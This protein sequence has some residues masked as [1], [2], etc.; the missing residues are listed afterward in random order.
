MIVKQSLLVSTMENKWRKVW[1]TYN[2]F[3][4]LKRLR[5]KAPQ[6]FDSITSLVF[7]FSILITSVKKMKLT[8]PKYIKSHMITNPREEIRKNIRG[9]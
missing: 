2:R 3:K 1:K 6:F 7:P 5:A 4:G 9:E 8:L